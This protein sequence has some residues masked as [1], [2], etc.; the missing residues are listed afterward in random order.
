MKTVDYLLIYKN[1]FNFKEFIYSALKEDVG[2]GDHTSLSTISNSQTGTM[3]LMIKD[4]G[5][6]AGVEAA[7]MIFEIVDK[8]IKFKKLIN[9]GQSIKPGDVAFVVEGNIQ[10]LLTTERLVLNIM[11]RMSGISTHTHSLMRICNGTKAQVIDTRKTTPGFRFFEKWAVAIGG[12]KN[13]RYGLFDM[14]LIKDNHID[15]AG[16]ISKAIDQAN[17]YLKYKKKKLNIEVEARSIKDVEEIIKNGKIHRI[18]L[19]NFSATKTKLAVSI[20][21]NKY[22]TEASGGINAKNIR[23]FAETGVDYISIGALT[24]QI[25]SLD[26]SLKYFK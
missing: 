16:G 21:N 2:D 22:A 5:V 19:D 8:K 1:N 7:K 25:K 6:L 15:F 10:K 26:L 3:K 18:L 9:D 12:G 24:H 11:Q 14:I 23:K 20:I 4:F 13:H 17:K